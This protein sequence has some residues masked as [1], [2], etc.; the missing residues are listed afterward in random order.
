[1]HGYLLAEAYAVEVVLA[2][3]LG[4]LLP[5]SLVL[6]LFLDLGQGSETFLLEL[7]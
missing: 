5:L 6:E 4:L 1:M 3:L 7:F 2:L